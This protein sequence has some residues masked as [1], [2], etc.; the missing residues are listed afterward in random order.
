MD[1]NHLSPARI[2]GLGGA[3]Y[4]YHRA[5]T[6]TRSSRDAIKVDLGKKILYNHSSVFQRLR[7]D[8]VA[9]SFVDECLADFIP[10]VGKEKAKLEAIEN[11]TGKRTETEMYE[12]LVSFRFGPCS[13]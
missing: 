4:M 12:P 5:S 3:D 6:T 8:D 11:R 7:L 10:V 13:P 9:D 2:R 1:E